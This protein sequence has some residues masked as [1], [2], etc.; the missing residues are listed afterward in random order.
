MN[1]HEGEARHVLK[2]QRIS[3]SSLL[4]NDPA[5]KTSLWEKVR[6]TGRAWKR[7]FGGERG[8]GKEGGR[9]EGSRDLGWGTT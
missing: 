6:G 3:I 7:T 9:G 4:F 5:Q 2:N 1:K 8:E